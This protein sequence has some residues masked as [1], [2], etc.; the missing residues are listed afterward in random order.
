MFC[1]SNLWVQGGYGLGFR[2]PGQVQISEE[3]WC[4]YEWAAKFQYMDGNL[5]QIPYKFYKQIINIE[6]YFP[7]KK[8]LFI[9]FIYY[10]VQQN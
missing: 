9:I 7:K 8:S 10:W 6:T 2:K 1:V 3:G 5:H 4:S